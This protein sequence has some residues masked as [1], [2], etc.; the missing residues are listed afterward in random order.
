M[1]TKPVGVPFA[2]PSHLRQCAEKLGYT[3]PATLKTVG[4]LLLGFGNEQGA[5]LELEACHAEIVRLI[6]VHNAA[7][8]SGRLATKGPPT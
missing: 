4:Q 8:T 7:M 3:D 1:V 2:L 5:R 6:D